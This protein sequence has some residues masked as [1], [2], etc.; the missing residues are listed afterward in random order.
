MEVTADDVKDRFPKEKILEMVNEEVE[1]MENN[2][3]YII[4]R[5]NNFNNI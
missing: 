5:L 4:Q 1:Q 2:I 3:E